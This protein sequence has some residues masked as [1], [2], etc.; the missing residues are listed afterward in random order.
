MFKFN[1]FLFS[2]SLEILFI[3]DNIGNNKDPKIVKIKAIPR[4]TFAAMPIVTIKSIWL[5]HKMNEL[6]F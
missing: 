6:E 5:I 4:S 1:I 2:V 3:S